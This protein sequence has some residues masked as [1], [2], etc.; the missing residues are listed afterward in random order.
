MVYSGWQWHDARYI[1]GYLIVFHSLYANS[2]N[3]STSINN[4]VT[5]VMQEEIGINIS[6]NPIRSWSSND[7]RSQTSAYI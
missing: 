7:T 1:R 2:F 5:V 4:T 6:I 3:Y